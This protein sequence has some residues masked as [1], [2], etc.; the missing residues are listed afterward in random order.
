[1]AAGWFSGWGRWLLGRLGAPPPFFTAPAVCPE[2][3]LTFR[4]IELAAAGPAV[5]AVLIVAP[6]E[7]VLPLTTAEAA[8]LFPPA[9]VTIP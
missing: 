1:M 2:A 8:I 4:P 7:T 9:E 6:V 5:E 3:V